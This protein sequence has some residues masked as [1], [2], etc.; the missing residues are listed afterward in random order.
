MAKL[1]LK[2]SNMV[3][4]YAVIKRSAGESITSQDLSGYYSSV[5]DFARAL[6]R[7]IT[8][9]GSVTVHPFDGGSRA[10]TGIYSFQQSDA[11]GNGTIY[12]LYTNMGAI[13]DISS[14]NNRVLG[15]TFNVQ[16]GT[17]NVSNII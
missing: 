10:S 7:L 9:S 17:V 3:I 1:I 15:L 16:E 11:Q 5:A 4:P 2:S 14:F 13:S 8:Q 6:R 12:I